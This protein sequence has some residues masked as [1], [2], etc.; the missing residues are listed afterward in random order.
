MVGFPH[1]KQNFKSDFAIFGFSDWRSYMEFVFPAIFA[2]RNSLSKE[3]DEIRR[4]KRSHIFGV[5][6]TPRMMEVYFHHS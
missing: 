6:K 5:G 3:I 2:G 1:K 4:I